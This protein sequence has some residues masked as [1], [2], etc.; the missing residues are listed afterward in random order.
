M[1]MF[2]PYPV[3]AEYLVNLPTVVE[4][5]DIQALFGHIDPEYASHLSPLLWY[6]HKWHRSGPGIGSTL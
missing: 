6:T 5:Y 3:V 1:Q 2:M 4:K